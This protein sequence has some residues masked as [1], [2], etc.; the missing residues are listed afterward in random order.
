MW[1]K[2]QTGVDVIPFQEL[3]TVCQEHGVLDSANFAGHINNAKSYFIIDKDGG[4]YNAKLTVP[5]I[6]EAEV[7]LNKYNKPTGKN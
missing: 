3:R 2:K 7:L 6:K 4:N 5:G 1:G